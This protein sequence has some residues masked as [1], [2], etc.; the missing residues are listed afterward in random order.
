MPMR[1]RY[2]HSPKVRLADEFGLKRGRDAPSAAGCSLAEQAR[3]GSA[4]FLGFM[5]PDAPPCG[6]SPI[7]EPWTDSSAD[8]PGIPT[9]DVALAHEYCEGGWHAEILLDSVVSKEKPTIGQPAA[10]TDD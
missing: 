5:R 2:Y 10:T 4:L 3:T 6:G 9:R 1:L 7:C 8:R